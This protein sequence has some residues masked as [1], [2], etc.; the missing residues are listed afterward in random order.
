[1]G[2]I[3]LPASAPSAPLTAVLAGPD[4]G[5]YLGVAPESYSGSQACPEV[6][7]VRTEGLSLVKS[8]CPIKSWTSVCFPRQDNFAEKMWPQPRGGNP[9]LRQMW[10]EWGSLLAQ[11]PLRFHKP[12][13]G[14]LSTRPA[15]SSSVSGS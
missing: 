14:P 1:M 2:S 8:E 9:V 6:R 5:R 13:P 10:G 12:L 4:P 15:L 11:T 3:H 7:G